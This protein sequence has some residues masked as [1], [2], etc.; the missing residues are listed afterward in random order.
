MLVEERLGIGG[1]SIVLRYAPPPEF[2]IVSETWA[3]ELSPRNSAN[4]EVAAYYGSSWGRRK[5]SS[6]VFVSGGAWVA[7]K[8]GRKIHFALRDGHEVQYSRIWVDP[9]QRRAGIHLALPRRRAEPTVAVPH[10]L[11]F[12]SLHLLV[13]AALSNGQGIIL[14]GC[15]VVDHGRGLVFTGSSG[16]GKSTM[17]RLW[18]G[19]GLFL[20]DERVILTKQEGRYMVHGTPWHGEI[21]RYSLASA[22]LSAVFFLRQAPENEVRSLSDAPTVREISRHALLP[23]WDKQ[24]LERSLEFLAGLAAAVPCRELSFRKEPEVVDFVRCAISR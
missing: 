20:N 12:P 8:Y 5:L 23:Y 18:D 2:Q 3:G 11:T 7:R 13:M 6:R 10:P 22:P 4:L 9:I 21:D 15:G 24:D 17:A 14:H 19:H 1:L 16:A